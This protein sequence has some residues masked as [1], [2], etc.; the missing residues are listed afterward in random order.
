MWL[1]SYKAI[2]AVAFGCYRVEV[3]KTAGH[4]ETGRVRGSVSIRRR[5]MD[6]KGMLRLL[7]GELH[8][9][10]EVFAY[11]VEFDVDACTYLKCVEVRVL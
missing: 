2:V 6:A 7:S 10:A 9:S 3:G 4:N 11:D 1:D 8:Q 5:M